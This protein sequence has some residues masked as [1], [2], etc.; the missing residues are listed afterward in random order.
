MG[1][2]R[3]QASIIPRNHGSR[4]VLEKC[5]FRPEGQAERYLRINDVWEDHDLYAITADEI[6]AG[7]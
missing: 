2:H 7:Y 6:R 1:L 4:R 5:H 3:L